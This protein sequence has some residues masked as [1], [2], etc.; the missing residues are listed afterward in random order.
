MIEDHLKLQWILDHISCCR[1]IPASFVKG[2][3]FAKRR[4]NAA[5]TDRA[6]HNRAHIR[7]RSIGTYFDM[8]VLVCLFLPLE[9]SSEIAFW[10]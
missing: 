4:K 2:F 3:T 10:C 1:R 9:S 8:H 5:P 6:C 7:C